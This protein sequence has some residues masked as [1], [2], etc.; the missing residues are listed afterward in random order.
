MFNPLSWERTDT[1][2]AELHLD[3]S[4]KG[5]ELRDPQGQMVPYQVLGEKRNG[6]A[7]D[8]RILL[9]AEN[10]PSLGYKTYRVVPRLDSGALTSP[11]QEARPV[12]KTN[13]IRWRLIPL[14]GA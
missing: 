7:Y 8:L 1:I 3:S 5:I 6:N 10:L 14:L 9:L 4:V 13:S 11:L 12:W 2:E